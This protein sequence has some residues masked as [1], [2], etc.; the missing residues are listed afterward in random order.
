MDINDYITESDKIFFKHEVSKNLPCDTYSMHT[1]N[2][3]ELIYFVS[4]NATHIIEDRKY[5]LKK[6]DL[7]L[8]RPFHYHFIQIDAPDDYERY[9]ILFDPSRHNIESTA[10]LPSDAEVINLTGNTAAED[11]FKKFDLYRENASPEI[12]EKLISIMLSELFYNISMFPLVNSDEISSAS[13]L[14]SKALRY[15]NENLC[16]ISGTREIANH[17]FVSE[18]Y[19][20]RIFKNELHESP[21]KYI[22]DKRLLLSQKMIASGEAP[23]YVCEKCGFGDYTSFY[24]NY[25]SFFGHS[26]SAKSRKHSPNAVKSTSP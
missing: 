9:D 5:K 2:M 20:F 11:I 17:L 13:P 10:L 21:K 6:G 22:M 23:G 4:G 3:Y 24:R 18:S 7:I 8:I 19:L 12:F 16:T 25:T 1:H 26:P 15:I 14:V